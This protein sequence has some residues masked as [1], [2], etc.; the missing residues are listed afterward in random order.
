MTRLGGGLTEVLRPAHSLRT[1]AVQSQ[2]TRRVE[3]PERAV[4]TRRPR[5]CRMPRPCSLVPCRPSHPTPSG[6]GY[7]IPYC[8]RSGP[9]ADPSTHA[10]RADHHHLLSAVRGD[11]AHPVPAVY[12]SQY[13]SVRA[14]T[15]I[16]S[17]HSSRL[18]SLPRTHRCILLPALARPPWSPC[19]H[20]PPPRS[21][22]RRR[23]AHDPAP[24]SA[25]PRR[26]R[27]G[28]HPRARGGGE[29]VRGAARLGGVGRGRSSGPFRALCLWL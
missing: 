19:A 7:G 28:A 14:L 29:G 23:T 5:P 22:P 11:L 26:G 2:G 16:S 25:R 1:N 9:I 17:S 4:S 21:L 8:S 12:V 15:L 27:A 24:H 13:L 3:Q 6:Y 20:A 18:C 10:P